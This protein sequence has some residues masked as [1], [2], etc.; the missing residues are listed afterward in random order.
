MAKRSIDRSPADGLGKRRPRRAVFVASL[1]TRRF[2]RDEFSADEKPLAWDA[3]GW[4]DLGRIA[5]RSTGKVF[6]AVQ[7]A[8]EIADVSVRCSMKA[9][10][11]PTWK[12]VL[13]TFRRQRRPIRDRADLSIAR[14]SAMCLPEVI[15]LR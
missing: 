14:Y 10:V 6:E 12:M 7:R 13:Q 5:A 9:L 15:G 4:Q 8:M 1:T 11:R 3:A 2:T